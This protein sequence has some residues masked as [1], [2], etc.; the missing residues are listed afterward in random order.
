MPLFPCTCNSKV[1]SQL[2]KRGTLIAVQIFSSCPTPCEKPRIPCST[3]FSQLQPETGRWCVQKS[4]PSELIPNI[5]PQA[6]AGKAPIYV[7]K[8]LLTC[9]QTLKSPPE[10][11]IGRE[12]TE[13]SYSYSS[14][15]G[16]EQPDWLHLKVCSRKTRLWRKREAVGFLQAFPVL[17]LYFMLLLLSV[18][19]MTVFSILNQFFS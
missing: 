18:C 3:L 14:G 5:L 4:H 13:L 16:W 11:L 9:T 2:P 1:R 17:K 12:E 7:F 6:G 10:W 19:D 15:G 8:Y